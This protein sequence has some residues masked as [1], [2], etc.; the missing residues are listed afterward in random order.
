MKSIT[1]YA[2]RLTYLEPFLSITVRYV[3]D[4]PNIFVKSASLQQFQENYCG[5]FNSKVLSVIMKRS[6]YETDFSSYS[7]FGAG[8]TKIIFLKALRW[9]AF[10][11]KQLL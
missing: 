7:N 5:L 10:K 9:W 8:N 6:P 3:E 11:K 4:K 2:V 1:N